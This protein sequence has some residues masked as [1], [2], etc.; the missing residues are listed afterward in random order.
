MV[1]VHEVGDDFNSDI[2][3]MGVKLPP[4]MQQGSHMP[5]DLVFLY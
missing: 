2:P 3:F 4:K 5:E 1:T